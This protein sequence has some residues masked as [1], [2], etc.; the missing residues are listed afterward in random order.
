MRASELIA[1]A[2]N[3]AGLRYRL[4]PPNE[5]GYLL[6]GISSDS[7][8]AEVWLLRFQDDDLEPYQTVV[9]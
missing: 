5:L 4:R 3:D 9:P 8:E 1:Q 2:A 7:Y 6:A